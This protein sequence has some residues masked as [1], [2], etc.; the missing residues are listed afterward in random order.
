MNVDTAM[1]FGENILQSMIGQSIANYSFKKKSQAVI[2]GM[3]FS[4][5]ID[6]ELVHVDPQLLLQQLTID[7]K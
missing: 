6:D 1:D 2:L 3:K 7:S 5:K 4:V